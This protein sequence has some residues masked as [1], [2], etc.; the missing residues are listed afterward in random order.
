VEREEARTV[1][2][3]GEDAV[4]VDGPRVAEEAADRVLPVERLERPRIRGCARRE[5]ER[6]QQTGEGEAERANHGHVR[7]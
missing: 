3:A 4:L 6:E 1:E 5:G 7:T 2:R